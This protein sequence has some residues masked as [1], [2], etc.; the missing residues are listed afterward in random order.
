MTGAI[1]STLRHRIGGRPRAD[2]LRTAIAAVT[3]AFAALAMAAPAAAQTQHQSEK[4][5]FTVTQVL[6]GLDHPWG[7]DFLPD[8]TIA[9]NERGGRMLLFSPDG[10][11][12]V[13]VDGV[14]EVMA[15]GQ[16]GLLDLVVAEDFATSGTVYFTYSEPGQGGSGTAAARARLVRDGEAARLEDL[17]VIARMEKKT[18]TTRHFGSRVVPAPDGTVFVTLGDRGD[19]DRAQDPFDHAGSVLR[20]NSDGSIPDD[21][22]FADGEE[23]LKEIWSIGHRNVQGA[24]IEPDTGRLWT[25]EHGARGGDE[26]NRPEAG[27]NYGWPVITY[28]RDYSGAK[29]GV[30]THAEGMEQ[31]LHYWDPSIA[32]SGMIF[33]TGDAIPEWK[34]NI[35]VGALAASLIS[36]LEVQDGEIAHEEQLLAG[37]YGRIRTLRNGPDGAI[38]FSTDEG[39]GGLYRIAPSGG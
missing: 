10:E 16:G 15:Q 26:I 24:A 17:K 18:S 4:A 34:G 5:A 25:V 22:P 29:I 31:P 28:G 12:P 35:F 21:N 6:S 36:R 33:Y 39:N 13:G 32:P 2:R 1:S 11:R 38:W 9:V 37:E 30:G 7:F 19:G 8:G 14:P 3:A 23:A 20:V 27:K